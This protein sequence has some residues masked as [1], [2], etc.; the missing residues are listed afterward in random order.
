LV[1]Y[2]IIGFYILSL[3]FIYIKKIKKNSIIY[4]LQLKLNTMIRLR[5]SIIFFFIYQSFISKKIFFFINIYICIFTLFT[6]SFFL[7]FSYFLL[8]LYYYYFSLFIY[9]I[10]F[11]NFFY[12]Y[13]TSF[14]FFFFPF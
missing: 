5:S 2:N 7:S 6:L 4:L 13:S 1:D 12:S 3:F 11:F 9:P 8:F 14:L 10:I